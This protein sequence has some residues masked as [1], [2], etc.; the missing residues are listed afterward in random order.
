MARKI[1]L[2]M[3]VLVMIASLPVFAA[4]TTPPAPASIETISL[5]KCLELAIKSSKQLQQAAENVNMAQA[6]VQEASGGFWPSI[7]Y[8]YSYVND[9]VSPSMDLSAIQD[10]KDQY[11]PAILGGVFS[12]MENELAGVGYSGYLSLTQPL[13]TGGRL[14]NSLKLAQLNLDSALEDQRKAKQQLSYNVKE[15][16]YNYWLAEKLLA[17]A[18]DSDNNLG[19]HYQRVTNLYNAGTASVIRPVICQSAMGK[20][21]AA[22]H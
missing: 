2:L 11:L 9:V 7:G 8:R 14:T 5:D 4:D 1:G 12:G 20:S 16:Y 22:Y 3:I 19:L 10:P 17:V 18:Q 13:Y 15:A 21:K 6:G